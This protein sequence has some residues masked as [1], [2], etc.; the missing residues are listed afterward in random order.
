[1]PGPSATSCRRFTPV[2]RRYFPRCRTLVVNS[3]GGSTDGTPELV[4][5]LHL[6]P[7]EVLLIDHPLYPVHRLSF[8]YHGIPGKGSAFRCIFEFARI[9]GATACAV[10]DSDLR[11]ISPEWV[12]LLLA[13]IVE[14][15]FDYV[16]P[17]Y[18]RHKHDG[19][20]TNN[21]VYPLTR[22]LYGQRVRQPIGGDF[23][24]SARLLSY[25]LARDVWDS[26]VARFGIDIWTTTTAICGGF[27]VG[28]VYL[29]TKLHDAKDPGADLSSM[30]VQVLGTVFSLMEEYEEIWR[31]TTG[32][33]P[34]PLMG[35][36]F[37]AGVEP[38]TVDVP[39]M[40]SRFRSG[41]D[42]LGD[43]WGGIFDQPDLLALRRLGTDGGRFC[44]P[45]GLWVRLVYSLAAAYHRRVIDRQHLIRLSLPLYLARVASFVNEV[46]AMDDQAVE[47][48]LEA[49]CLEFE[50]KKP[51]LVDR[52][53]LTR[54]D[55]EG[56]T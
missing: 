42:N 15:G 16:A 43:V 3:D 25:Y 10:V 53:R 40:V 39:R 18:V 1:M 38:I 56:R 54:D 17:Y 26:D 29:G 11:S 37:A 51:F 12:H 14:Q 22:A 50:V 35:F 20:I 7:A 23:G 9:T 52:W 34:T 4:T 32:S 33:V 30:L 13:P 24:I 28:Q 8:P 6:A 36:R 27:K 46:A 2:W 47:D 45:D 48:R 49:L 21:L 41:V 55:H 44:L 31:S 19:T 5:A